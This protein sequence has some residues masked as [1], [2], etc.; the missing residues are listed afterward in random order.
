MEK[1][2]VEKGEALML[3]YPNFE[4]IYRIRMPHY[5]VIRMCEISDIYIMLQRISIFDLATLEAMNNN[6][7]LVLSN[8]GGNLDL[9]KENNIILIDVKDYNSGVKDIL[10]A[11]LDVLKKKN[12]KIFEK[13][14]SAE[15]FSNNY[16]NTL[17][18]VIEI[19]KKL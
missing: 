2:L 7:A 8:I 4:F 17:S 3:K 18:E 1:T 10:N 9:N 13:Y 16:K 19:W 15:S 5:E 6:C 12:K 14:F 11:D